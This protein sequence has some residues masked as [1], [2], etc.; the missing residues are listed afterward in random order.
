MSNPLVLYDKARTALAA[1]KRVDEA[2]DIRDKA[3]AM[4]VYAKQ[5]A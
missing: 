1:A 3:V 5:A 2:K 4:Q